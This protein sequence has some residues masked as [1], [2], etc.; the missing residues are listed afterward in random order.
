MIFGAPFDQ[1]EHDHAERGLQLRVLEQL[2][3]DDLR[4]RIALQLD[5]DTNAIAIRLIAQVRDVR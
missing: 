5:H 1:S 3:Q 2:I 4:N